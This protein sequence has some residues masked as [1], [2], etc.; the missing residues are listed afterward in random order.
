MTRE[1]QLAKLARRA[2]EQQL[3]AQQERRFH[4][5]QDSYYL[6]YAIGDTHLG[7]LFAAFKLMTI[8]YS[9]IL[10]M[11]VASIFDR[12]PAQLDL[13]NGVRQMCRIKKSRG[14]FRYVIVTPREPELRLDAF[15][16]FRS[17]TNPINMTTPPLPQ[18]LSPHDNSQ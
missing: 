14:W 12:R 17:R 10:E 1:D 4:E 13:S 15:H 16:K 9:Q 18:F 3:L 2:D 8:P 11:E 5:L 7:I 6:H